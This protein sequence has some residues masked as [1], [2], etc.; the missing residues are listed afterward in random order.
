[1]LI[2]KK[3]K[4]VIGLI[5]EHIEKTAECVYAA[6]DN[7]R[8]YLNGNHSDSANAVS[9]DNAA[10]VNSLEA[11]A[12]SLLRE[13]R[14]LLYSGAYLPQMRS[15][16]YRLMSSVDMVTNRAEDCSD[17]V[18]LQSPAIPEEYR[19]DIA[20]IIELTDETFRQFYKAL[21]YYFGP[22]DKPDK[23]RMGGEKISE[24]ESQ[25]DKLERR[26]TTR[27]FD[28]QLD[29]SDKIHLQQCLAQIT[30]ISDTIEDAAD[31]LELINVKS[32]V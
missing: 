2:F 19:S 9:R 30:R 29:K 8:I 16:I 22:K 13:I 7:I 15:D 17:F 20:S 11:E 28:S 27:I 23:V 3:E 14:E 25:I 5:I 32:I 4:R 31:E 1:M 24:L 26:V 10:R 21:K 6:T 18:H 12:D